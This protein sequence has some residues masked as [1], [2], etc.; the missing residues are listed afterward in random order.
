MTVPRNRKAPT[1]RKPTRG[2]S[3]STAASGKQYFSGYA[4]T[5]VS[6]MMIFVIGWMFLAFVYFLHFLV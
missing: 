1:T 4:A 5:E 2:G 3:S 6:P